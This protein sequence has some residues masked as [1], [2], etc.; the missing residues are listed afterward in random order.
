MSMKKNYSSYNESP[1]VAKS[2][3]SKC[4]ENSEVKTVLKMHETPNAKFMFTK[5]ET[6]MYIDEKYILNA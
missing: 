1:A 2:C 6:G 5:M 3:P 4:S